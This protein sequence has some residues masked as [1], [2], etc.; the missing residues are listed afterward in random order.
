MVMLAS[1]NVSQSFLSR[2]IG[3]LEEQDCHLT[4]EV[5]FSLCI[6]K[7]SVSLTSILHRYTSCT[8]KENMTYF[9]YVCV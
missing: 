1:C 6:L 4:H 8:T 7:L 5:D 9:L 3:K 2:L